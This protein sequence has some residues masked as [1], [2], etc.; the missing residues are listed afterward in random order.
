ML[1]IPPLDGLSSAISNLNKNRSLLFFSSCLLDYA[2]VALSSSSSRAD[3][4]LR[5]LLGLE[6]ERESLADPSIFPIATTTILLFLLS[7]YDGLIGF[8]FTHK[9]ANARGSLFVFIVIICY[10]YYP[11]TRQCFVCV[12]CLPQGID[13]RVPTTKRRH[14]YP[15]PPIARPWLLFASL[16]SL[17]IK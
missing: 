7:L 8:G 12:L 1:Y 14:H 16:M 13:A 9:M 2:A 15:I 4:W 10:D 6:R 3:N 17:L 11:P 5:D